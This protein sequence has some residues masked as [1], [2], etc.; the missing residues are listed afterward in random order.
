MSEIRATTISDAA[1]TG[2]ITLTKQVAAKAWVNWNGTGTV[3]IRD[4]E[5]VSS[6][7]DNSTGNY[8][9]NLSSAMSDANY[10]FVALGGGTSGSAEVRIENSTF[11]TT[12]TIG[13]LSRNTSSSGQDHL[14]L[15]GLFHGDLA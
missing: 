10:C 3:A 7:T 1:G 5:N 6:I 12:T 9:I 8:T 14:D 4:S 15:N 11:R 13:L 2:P